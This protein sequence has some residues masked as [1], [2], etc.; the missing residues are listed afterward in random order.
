MD[1]FIKVYDDLLDEKEIT[2][3]ENF[4]N[5]VNFPYF[6]KRGTTIENNDFPVVSHSFLNEGKPSSEFLI[7]ATSLFRVFLE[8]SNTKY[9]NLIRAQVNLS[10][11]IT[12]ETHST[13]HVDSDNPHHVLICY[14]NGSDGNTVMF[15]NEK[16]IKEIE[17]KKGRFILFDGS[18]KHAHYPCKKNKT[19][20]VMN[21]NLEIPKE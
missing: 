6:Y 4:F 21:Y 10:F 18:I 16:I 20:M 1:K 2:F 5:Q 15:E 17:P 19:R 11:A 13:P 8:K 3:Y 9:T 7:L 14:L 12:S